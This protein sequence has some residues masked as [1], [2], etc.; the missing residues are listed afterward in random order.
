MM[1]PH[2]FG[3]RLNFNSHLHILVP[4]GGPSIS[5]GRGISPSHTSPRRAQ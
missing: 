4:G 1:V 2:T 3:G 5:R